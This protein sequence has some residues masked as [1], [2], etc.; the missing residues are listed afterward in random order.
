VKKDEVF[1]GVLPQFFAAH[2][3]DSPGL[4]FHDFPSRIRIGYVVRGDGNYLYLCGEE[5]SGLSITLEDLHSAAL[6]NLAVLPSAEISVGKVPGGAEGWIHATEDNFAAVRILLP[7][8]QQIFRQELGEE[9]LLTL[10]H[11]DDC[12]CWSLRQ[13]AERQ[14]KHAADALAAFLHE[15]YNLTPDVLLCSQGQFR[16]QRRQVV[17]EPR[18]ATDGGRNTGS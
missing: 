18:T 8:V 6:E 17:G 2:W 14:E 11:R 5:F 12:F 15:E 16:V 7:K 3:L 4:V 9:F 1:S 13:T 10:P